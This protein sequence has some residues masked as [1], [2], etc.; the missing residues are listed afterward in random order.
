MYFFY[1]DESGSR[2]PEVKATGADGTVREK[3]HLYVLAAVGLF[4]GRWYRFDRDIANL[5][6]ELAD[7]LHRL[8]GTEFTLVDC[9]VK[10]TTLRIPRERHERSPFL[11]ALPSSDL[12]RLSETFL[13]QIGAHNMPLFAIVVDKRKLLPYI[14]PELLHKKAYE[15]L[16]ERVEHYLAEYHE[17]HHGLIV[18]DD[19]QKQL[20][21]AVAMKHAYFQREGNQNLRFRHIVEY[22][23]FTDSRLSNGIQLADLWAYN[24][25]RAFRGKE[26]DYPYFM[27]LL[28]SVYR[29]ERT[30]RDKL[31]GL[32]V[33]PDDSELVRFAAE[34]YREYLKGR[35]AE[36][37]ET[38]GGDGARLG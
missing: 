31:D 30:A 36:G 6:L 5:K 15:L 1:V 32:K 22:P 34:G 18:I 19:T 23:F 38:E 4:E 9:E 8:H 26:F 33:F 29:S 10:S 7:Y 28:P 3:D 21:H 27:S 13:R 37:G 35:P 14:T 12:T 24:V 11:D 25:Y 2:D 16:L 17:K 20:N